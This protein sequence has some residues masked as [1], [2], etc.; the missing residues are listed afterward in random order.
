MELLAGNLGTLAL[1]VVSG[2]TANAVFSISE[3][4]CES[5]TRVDAH[6]PDNRCNTTN[7]LNELL[8][9]VVRQYGMFRMTPHNSSSNRVVSRLGCVTDGKEE[10]GSEPFI[11]IK[12][13]GKSWGVQKSFNNVCI[14]LVGIVQES[15]AQAVYEFVCNLNVI[16]FDV[17]L[18]GLLV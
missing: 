14:Q 1:G 2:L 9:T 18:G 7:L 15:A 16:D 4:A 6:I 12:L 3:G 17:G 11:G 5:D 13:G 8:D 10:V